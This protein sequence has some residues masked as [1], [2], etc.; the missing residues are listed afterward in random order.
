MSLKFVLSW[1]VSNESCNFYGMLEMSAIYPLILGIVTKVYDDIVDVGFNVPTDVVSI[2]QSLIIFFFTL[3]TFGDFYFSFACLVVCAV[4]NGFD[5]PFWKSFFPICVLLTVINLPHAGRWVL[6]KMFLAL[7]PLAAILLGA[8][9]EELVF[10]EE[11]SPLK[12]ISRATLIFGFMF[13]A[14]ILTLGVLPIPSYGVGPLYKTCLFFITHMIVSVGTMSYLLQRDGVKEYSYREAIREKWKRVKE[15]IIDTYFVGR[16][17][18]HGSLQK[19]V[20]SIEQLD[21]D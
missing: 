10:P 16:S 7:F 21:S 8:Y 1:I 19:Q 13:A 20:V 17:Y 18:N 6:L 11:V 14:W 12:L 9:I 4:N 2:L 5:N 3:T 15:A